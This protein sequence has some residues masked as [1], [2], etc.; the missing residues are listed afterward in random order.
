MAWAQLRSDSAKIKKSSN[1]R[2]SDSAR[3]THKFR[4]IKRPRSLT[5]CGY[6]AQNGH[7]QSFQNI[8]ARSSLFYIEHRTPYI[9]P[10]PCE[11]HVTSKTPRSASMHGNIHQSP[12]CFRGTVRGNCQV[13]WQPLQTVTYTNFLS[14]LFESRHDGIAGALG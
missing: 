3:T 8:I 1:A 10:L 14:W 6:I 7:T 4:K 12:H 11:V 5:K 9:I 2:S 13:L